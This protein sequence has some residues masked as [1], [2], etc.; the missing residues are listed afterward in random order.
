MLYVPLIP[1]LDEGLCNGLWSRS[2]LEEMDSRFKAAVELAFA[3]GGES[4][5]AASATVKMNGK[6][7]ADEIAI[8]LAWRWLQ[9]KMD[10]SVDVS[11][12]EVVA[13]MNARCPGVTSTRVREGFEE[14]FRRYGP[15]IGSNDGSGDDHGEIHQ[16]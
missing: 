13:F 2:Q 14:R 8:E 10:A 1:D 12:V 16:G 6:P 11:F 7:R 3:N 15:V 4:R 9:G 5:A